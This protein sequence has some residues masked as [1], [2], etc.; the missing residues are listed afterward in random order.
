M[1]A[2]DVLMKFFPK[3]DQGRYQ[4]LTLEWWRTLFACFCIF[5]WVGHWLEIPYCLF[6]SQFGIVDPNYSAFV[7]PLYT[8][9]WVYGIGAVAMTLFIEPFR[10]DVIAKR[11][12]R[13]GAVLEVFAYTVILAAI[14]ETVIGLIIN[15]PNHL[16][17][18]PYWDNSG[19]PLNILGQGWLVNDLVIG[20]T[21]IVYLWVLYPLV[22]RWL[23]SMRPWLANVITLAL[24]AAIIVSALFAYVW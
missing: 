4:I 15:Q 17:E 11:R 22:D 6:M 7:E 1:A 12:T 20:I 3:D 2:K 14:L 9:Y 18:F 10:E 23:R 8:P 24:I 16:G 13:W 21:A 19:L 5:C